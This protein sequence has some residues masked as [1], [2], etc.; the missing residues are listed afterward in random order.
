MTQRI[1]TSIRM[2][3]EMLRALKYRAVEERK[4]INLIICEAID[5]WLGSVQ[6]QENKKSDPFLKIIGIAMSG[7]RDGSQ[8][9][10]EYL[11]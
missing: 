9:H 7:I 2:P 10:D 8:K 3:E 1:A 6:Q 11:Y 5:H 4:S